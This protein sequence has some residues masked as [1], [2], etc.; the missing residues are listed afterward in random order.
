MNN[1]IMNNSILKKERINSLQV[2]KALAFLEIFIKHCGGSVSGAFG[3]SVFLVLSG[4]L[5]FKSYHERELGCSL[6]ESICFSIG[7]IKK[8]YP[9]HI[10]T[11]I[12]AI[13]L[14]LREI[15][16]NYSCKA[17]FDFATKILL[18]ITLLQSWIP[19][20]VYYFS[21][22]GVAWYLSVCCLLYAAFPFILKVIKKTNIKA[23]I[24]AVVLFFSIQIFV[25]VFLKTAASWT[26]SAYFFSKWITYIFPF[27]RLGDFVIGCC[28]G[29]VFLNYEFKM[30]TFISTFL[31]IITFLLAITAEY[32]YV[33][34]K[35]AL[36][37]SY[38]KYTAIFT[39]VSL[40][41]VLLF[42]INKGLIS[43]A[44]TCKPLIFLG[45]I[46]AYTFF[47]HQIVIRYINEI[48]LKYIHLPD[49]RLTTI[50]VSIISFVFSILISVLY[51]EVERKIRE[52]K[53]SSEKLK[54]K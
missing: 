38:F 31:E 40:F 48:N 6:K 27:A 32:I 46:S 49:S 50:F 23:C 45:D 11:M 21:F 53:N 42:A 20:S 24:A 16:Y 22:N 43:R 9:L 54:L 51:R 39:P 8:L 37:S 28:L 35:G 30:G 52:G 3:V 36:G 25:G 18:N 12:L 5:M 4:F 19:S 10:I 26:D 17:T 14:V 15:F 7:K 33:K 29:K 34:E 41:L 44:L 47:I 2:V 13:L 1:G